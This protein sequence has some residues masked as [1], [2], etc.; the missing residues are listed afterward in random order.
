MA[1]YKD[2]EFT[3]FQEHTKITTAEQSLMK[4]TVN[5]KKEPQEGQE[6]QTHSIIKSHTPQVGDPQI[7]E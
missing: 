1:E 2:L 7:K 3:S 4:K 6:G 5:I